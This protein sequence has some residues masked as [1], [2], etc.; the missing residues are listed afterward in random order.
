M[1]KEFFLIALGAIMMLTACEKIVIP[2]DEEASPIPTG[3]LDGSAQLMI[4]TRTGGLENNAV[5]EGRIYIFNQAGNC[6][7][8]LS[9]DEDNNSAVAHLAAGSYS[10]YAVGG[11]DL[12]RFVLPTQNNATPT[13]VITRQE[14]KVMD[15]LLMKKADVVLE[16]GESTNLGMVLEHKV[17]AISD[18]EI[19][20]VPTNVTKVEVTLTPLYSSI[21]LNG[22]YPDT[23]TESYKIA[24]TKQS[25]G[26]TWKALPNQML[27][28][29]QGKPT[30]K[31]S[32]T[33]AE[34]TQ[35]YSY[36][37]SE[38]LPAN[39]HV[40]IKGTYEAAQGVNITGI[41]TASNWGEDRTIEFDFNDENNTLY[42]PVANKYCN[43]YY[44]LSVDESNRTAVLLAEST[45]SYTAPDANYDATEAWTSALNTAMTSLAKPT[46]ISNNWRLPTKDEIGLILMNS[47]LAK[48]NPTGNTS[49]LY[50]QDG[51]VI[52]RAYA[53][54]TN[55]GYQMKYG[56]GFY[57][58]V[59]PWPVINI[60]Y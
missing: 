33:T 58:S 36:T 15:D 55:E 30:I 24:L 14:G 41:L 2:E 18:V 34:G 4:S 59:Y 22:E 40:I 28:P 16:D 37:A 44:V 56:T 19:K 31:I 60:S 53:N 46:G 17:L 45:V 48:L 9:T 42:T 35:G 26:K 38:E 25:D 12:S 7:Q 39:H 49:S 10:L 21:R 1:K 5:A 50:Y 6:V 52:N 8:M 47:K 29:S 3:E 43:G 11:D 54:Y 23:P 32:F 51:N 20:K 57:S 27:F 13:S